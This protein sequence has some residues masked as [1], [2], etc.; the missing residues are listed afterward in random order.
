MKK[1]RF[2]QFYARIKKQKHENLI[3]PCQNNENHEI[4]RIPCQNNENHENLINQRQNH[5][6]HIW[7][8]LIQRQNYKIMKI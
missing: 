5:E 7:F 2:I 8:F 6:N 1:I 3:I 4:R